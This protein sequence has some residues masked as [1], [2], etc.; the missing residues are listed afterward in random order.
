[1]R[2]KKYLPEY[3]YDCIVG[4]LINSEQYIITCAIDG[5]IYVKKRINEAA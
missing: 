5:G 2:L 4:E 3:I 1:M